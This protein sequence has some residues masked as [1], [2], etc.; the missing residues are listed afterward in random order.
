M[1]RNVLLIAALFLMSVH[2]SAVAEEDPRNAG[3]AVV[4]KGADVFKVIYKTEA[5]SRIKFNIYNA[6]S[7]LVYSEVMNSDGFIRPLKFTGLVPGEYT[8][9]ISDGS[10]KRTERVNYQP[11]KLSSKKVIHVSKLTGDEEKFL[12][13]LAKVSSEKVT[14]NFYDSFERLV[15]S[16]T[17][18]VSGEF[19]QVY[20]IK[21]KNVSS[22]EVVDEAGSKKV[23][24][25]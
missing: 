17:R 22:V 5:V 19:A 20:N 4:A 18:Q 16:E 6:S 10:T 15:Y 1:K 25:F 7:Q 12:V 23:T 14:I 24:R 11:E 8:I 3:L 21:R 9:E 2:I 13:T